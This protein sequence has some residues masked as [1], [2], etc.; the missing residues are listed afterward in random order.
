DTLAAVTALLASLGADFTG[1]TGGD[2]AWI[3]TGE[4]P[5]RRVR[6]AELRLPGLTRGEAVWSSRPCEDRPLK[7]GNSGPGKGVGGHSGE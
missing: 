6:E 5:A 4:L 3:V 1:T 7:P 2:P